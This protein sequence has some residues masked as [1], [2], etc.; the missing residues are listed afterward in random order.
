MHA[1]GGLGT[2]ATCEAGVRLGSVGWR[3]AAHRAALGERPT[4]R[5]QRGSEHSCEIDMPSSSEE[6]G[7]ARGGE[8]DRVSCEARDAIGLESEVALAEKS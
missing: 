8:V 4:G 5:E 6:G 2:T 3:F 1:E 7:D